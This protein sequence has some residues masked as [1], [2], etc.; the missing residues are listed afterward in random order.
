[1]T[2]PPRR[3]PPSTPAQ[4]WVQLAFGAAAATLLILLIWPFVPALVTASVLALILMPVHDRIHRR[5]GSPRLAATVATGLS[6]VGVI[7]PLFLVGRVAL[8]QLAWLAE[9]LS[10]DEALHALPRLERTADFW[11]D[12]FGMGDVQ[13]G[14]AVG[15]W[16]QDAPSF[17]LGRAFG[18]LAGLGGLAV[19]VG[20]A[21][22]TLFF[23]FRDKSLMRDLVHTLIPL[24]NTRTSELLTRGR[25][26]VGAVVYGNLLVAVVQ[27]TL[28]G[29][30]FLVLSIPAPM[31]WATV[32]TITSLVPMVGAGVVWLPAAI[33]L[34]ATGS[35]IRGVILLL[36]GIFVIGTV[37]N[38]IRAAFVGAKAGV[39]PVVPFLGVLGG[40]VLFGAVGVF[41]GPVLLAEALLMME[42]MRRVL[43]PDEDM[44]E[45]T[46]LA[47]PPEASDGS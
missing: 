20:V 12:R 8:S 6:I 45:A 31:V 28:G 11:L 34:I 29:L 14:E 17:L 32:M 4:L 1:M 25:E 15:T 19:Q 23:L 47:M 27:G 24:D 30:A 13:A 7:V 38:V 26:V 18:L 39:H 44:S 35:V 46:L 43:Y 21:I 42:M 36:F 5:I 22:F 16:L 10:G 9:F 37:D 3:D 41:V 2:T 33:I 40:L